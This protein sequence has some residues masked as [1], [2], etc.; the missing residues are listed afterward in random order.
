LQKE[1]LLEKWQSQAKRGGRLLLLTMAEGTH[2]DLAEQMIFLAMVCI[3]DVVRKEA[4]TAVTALRA[5]G[6]QVVMI[7]GDNPMTARAVAE[8]CGILTG[9]WNEVLSGAELRRMSDTELKRRLP[10]LAVVA[11]AV[12]TDKTRLVRLSQELGLVAG[13]TGDGVNDAPALKQADVGFAMG[14]GTEVAREAG[15]ILISDDNF[16]SITRAILYGR[17]IFDSIRKFILFQLTMNLSAVGICLIGPF[18]GIEEPVTVTQMLWVNLIMDTLGGLAFAGEPPRR[19]Y[20][21]Q[22]P[23]SRDAKLITKESLCRIL[24]S[25]FFTVALSIWFLKSAY[26]RYRLS[27]TGD[28]YRLSAFFAMFIFCGIFISFNSRTSRIHL[29]SGLAGNKPF[30]AIMA[31][32]S[33]MQLLFI[34]CGGEAFRTVPLRGAD[35]AFAIFTALTVVPFD[36]VWKLILRQMRK[37]KKRR[38]QV[39]CCD[40]ASLMSS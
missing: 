29:F 30:I 9:K 26:V 16:A 22:L 8:E 40:K 38:S 2:T 13:M 4:R 24:S 6:V 5:A 36:F 33:V 39:T 18:I 17:T 20:M 34:Y 32:I 37:I 1:Q 3:E 27:C 21:R 28:A 11:R 7:T 25:G 19:A 10:H 23:K 14:S 12:P 31:L 15:D 35:L